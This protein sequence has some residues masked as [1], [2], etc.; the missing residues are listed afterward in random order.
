M[1]YLLYLLLIA[2][3]SAQATSGGGSVV[4]T[5]KDATGAVIPNAKVRVTNTAT[6]VTHP[7]VTNAD[8]Y[9]STSTLIIGKYRVQVEAAGMKSWQGELILETGRTVEINQ[10]LSHGTVAETVNFAE[11]LHY[12]SAQHG[13]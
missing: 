8:G 10:V 9:F 1:R 13:Y 4:G 7:T 5:V 3:A 12:T 11:T 6:E 2:S